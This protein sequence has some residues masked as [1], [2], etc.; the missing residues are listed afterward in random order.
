MEDF[1]RKAYGD[2]IWSVTT[3]D[4]G[5]RKIPGQAI[6]QTWIVEGRD[7]IIALDSPIP[8]R[9][10][11]RKYLQKEF[12]KDIL[13]VNTHGH[14][15]HIGCNGQFDEVF[16]SERDIPLLLGGGV[17][18]ADGDISELEGRLPYRIRRLADYQT[19]SIGE[20]TLTVLPIGGHTQGSIALY[21]EK[22]GALFSGD[23]VSR[24]ILYGLSGW[25]DMS[26]YFRNLEELEKYHITAIYSM[27]DDFS[28]PA[29]QPEKIRRHIVENLE[30]TK[31]TW[32][33]PGEDTV[34]LMIQIGEEESDMDY[35]SFVMPDCRKSEVLDDLENAKKDKGELR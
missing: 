18:P 15:D 23:A 28:L 33:L 10:G 14:I 32:N 11:F 16:I 5:C 22:T 3:E 2:G 4:W 6:M 30:T 27:H 35:F 12:K 8:E 13:M 1:I 24:R 26:V 29:D 9:Q 25:T 31:L 17:H 20:R 21:D 19:L 7:T 34:F